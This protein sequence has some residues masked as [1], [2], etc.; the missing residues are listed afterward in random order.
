MLTQDNP[1]MSQCHNMRINSGHEM[2]RQ[3][4]TAQHKTTLDITRP[5]G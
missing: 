2:A 3:N 1:A 4:T 5:K